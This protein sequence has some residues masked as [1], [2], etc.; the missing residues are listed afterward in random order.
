[1]H[2]GETAFSGVNAMQVSQIFYQNLSLSASLRLPAIGMAGTLAMMGHR[3]KYSQLV[4]ALG[5]LDGHQLDDIGISHQALA[6]GSVRALPPDP[7]GHHA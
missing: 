6:R 7:T 2:G 1:M 4:E 5:R 3:R